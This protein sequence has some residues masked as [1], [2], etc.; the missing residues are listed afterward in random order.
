MNDREFELLLEGCQR[1]GDDYFAEQARFVVLVCGRLGLR[2]GE[3]SHM[4]ESW[5]NWRRSTIEI[6]RHQSCDKGRDGGICG[7]CE[8]HAQQMVDVDSNRDIDA[9][10]ARMWGPKTDQAIREV[11]F[12]H[13]P[14]VE[15]VIERFFDRYDAWPLSTQVPGRRIKKA[16]DQ[17]DELDSANIYPHCLR[18]TAAT[19]WAA[20]GLDTLPLQSLMGW[21]QPSTARKYVRTSTEATRRA[22]A[23]TL[24]G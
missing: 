18:A 15:L 9:M 8:Q 20:R 21:A 7:T 12:D 6:P 3:L 17:I 1:I 23:G 24:I 13:D 16:A 4:R 22:I 19:H 10:R 14:R 11:P 5:I 2:V